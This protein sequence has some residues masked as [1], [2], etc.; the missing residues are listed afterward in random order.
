MKFLSFITVLFLLSVSQSFSQQIAKGDIV[1]DRQFLIDKPELTATDE[2]GN[3]ISIRPHRING[4]LRNYYVEFFDNLNF[5]ERLEIETQN[6]T[7]ILD[8]FILNNKAHIFIKERENQTISLR[9]DVVDLKSKSFAK[10]ILL[11]T[12]KETDKPL[13]KALRDN[14]FIDLQVSSN[15]VLNFPVVEEQSTFAYI[16]VFSKNL[17]EVTQV[18]VFADDNISYRNT[19]FLNAKF[20]NDKAYVLFQLKD[21]EDDKKRFYRLI[22]HTK[23]GEQYIDI[24]IPEDSYELINSSIKDKHLIIA[25][26]YSHFKKGGYKGFTYY[27]INLDTFNLE[28]QQQTE[29]I[30][31]KAKS[32]FSGLFTGNRNIDINNLFIDDDLNTF[33]IGQFYILRKQS[34]PIVFPIA[35]FSIGTIS[36]FVTVNP[37]SINYKVFDD[38]L[39]GKIS[40]QGQI[41]W[42]N[43]LELRQTEKIKSKSNKR[44]SSTF[45]CFENN[46]INIFINGY[47]DLDK[48]KLIVKQDK[49]LSKTN[50]Y[51]ITVN[52]HGGITPKIVFPNADSETLFRAETAVKS[53]NIIYILGQGN[54]RKQLLK[55]NF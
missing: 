24:E 12:D 43:V 23:D 35:S 21:K 36:A 51:N 14:Y 16:K 5:T 17:E 52:Q 42:D 9:L 47:I 6:D 37:I 19:S 45:T 53:K 28:S 29:F 10:K 25:G 3:F 30:N 54:M 20:I 48:E 1:K 15:L 27:K 40:P 7:D 41:T 49:R 50:F 32:Y 11:Q 2:F 31:E 55:L 38:I 8:V 26:L 4:T 34:A 33:I 13:F 44:D 39:I 18:N 46:Q 22:E